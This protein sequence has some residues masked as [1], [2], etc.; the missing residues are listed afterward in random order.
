MSIQVERHHFTVDEY[1]RMGD[2]GIFTEDDRVELIDGE[3]IRMSPIGSRHAAC[4]RRLD[5]L[6][7]RLV[8]QVAQVSAQNPIRVSDFSEPQPDIALLRPLA[9]FYA[10]GHPTPADVLLV[11][12]VAETSVEYDREIKGPLYARAGIAEMWLVNLR[13]EF[14]EIYTNPAGGSYQSVRRATRG[15]SF[16]SQSLPDMTLS[17]DEILG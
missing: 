2:A 10:Q 11:V 14:V 4:V 7:N 6:L 12:E 17:V 3:I 15:E 13:E 5:A 9:D 1:Y 8:S 16:A